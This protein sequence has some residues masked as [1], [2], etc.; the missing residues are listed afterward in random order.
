VSAFEAIMLVCF[1]SAWP[2]SIYRSWTSR[3]NK[4]KSLPFL[5]IVFVGYLSGVAHKLL[6][7]PDPVLYL[8]G[9]NGVMVLI[10]MALFV[11]NRRLAAGTGA[12]A[13]G[14]VRL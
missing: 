9:L 4:G 12:G 1:G 2:F 8:Y 14:S 11:R 10:D 3:S 13:Q 6:Y 7:S 5:A